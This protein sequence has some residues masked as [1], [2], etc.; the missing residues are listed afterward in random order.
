M[1]FK[2]IR[3]A[4]CVKYLCKYL[5]GGKDTKE[6]IEWVIE[7]CENGY[8]DE[9]GTET[10][11]ANRSEDYFSEDD[12]YDN[13]KYYCGSGKTC[14]FCNCDVNIRYNVIGYCICVECIETDDI[15]NLI[16]KEFCNIIL[17]AVAEKEDELKRLKE[18]YVFDFLIID[19][20]GIYILDITTIIKKSTVD[21]DIIELTN[22]LNMIKTL[23]YD[24]ETLRELCKC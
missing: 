14:M 15:N 11:S 10:L 1:S 8:C 23:I 2:K 17:D 12:R 13:G 9:Y 21:N 5:T 20:F 18:E 7:S 19:S 22:E 6:E 4:T 16:T 24:V 3:V